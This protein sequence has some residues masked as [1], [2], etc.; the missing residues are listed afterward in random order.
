MSDAARNPDRTSSSATVAINAPP[1][2]A[3]WSAASYQANARLR[4]VCVVSRC[5]HAVARVPA[6]ARREREQQ[7]RDDHRREVARRGR[8][9]RGHGRDD[10]ADA[11]HHPFVDAFAQPRT[12]VGARR[13][14]RRKPRAPGAPAWSWV[15]PRARARAR[16]GRARS[17][18]S[19]AAP[20]S[21]AAAGSPRK[22][23]DARGATAPS[24]SSAITAGTGT[25]DARYAPTACSSA[26][27]SSSPDWLP[28][29]RI[30][31][32]PMPPANPA[33]EPTR[34]RRAFAATS[35]C[36]VAY[37][38]GHQRPLH[39]RV[40]P[41]EHQHGQRQRGTG[42]PSSRAGRASA[43][44]PTRARAMRPRRSDPAP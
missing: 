37:Q 40:G 35:S 3:S 39:D 5:E 13:S 25:R 30:R 36:V 19:T 9:Q 32:P 33:M 24:A 11:E 27:V 15:R 10:R 17:R 6:D 2:Q 1:A 41:A 29:R 4:V 8:S 7:H 20:P 44:R 12:H 31:L 42:G 26:A 43:R 34:D 28:N 18:S 23:C 38:R 21:R 14:S 16:G 22:E